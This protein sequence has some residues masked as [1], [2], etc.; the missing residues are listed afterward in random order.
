MSFKLFLIHDLDEVT[1]RFSVGGLL[2]L[3][4]FD[5]IIVW[6]PAKYGG[7]EEQ[8]YP[9][10]DIWFPK[11]LQAKAFGSPKSV[12]NT[13]SEMDAKVDYTGLVSISITAVFHLACQV[14]M[15]YY[16]FDTQVISTIHGGGIT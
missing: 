10:S 14:D 15:T 12:T 8:M 6:D 3:S 11:L 1:Q 7:I 9:L 5:E 4:W 2:E 16:P 13:A